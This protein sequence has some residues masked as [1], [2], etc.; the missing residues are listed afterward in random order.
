MHIFIHKMSISSSNPTFDHLLESSDGDNF[1]KWSNIGFGEEVMQLV[2]IKV[3][4]THIIWSS[5]NGLKA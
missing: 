3:N 1:S 5:D 4:F 2:L